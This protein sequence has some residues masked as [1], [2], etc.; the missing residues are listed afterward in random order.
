MSR[1]GYE[2]NDTICCNAIADVRIGQHHGLDLFPGLQARNDPPAIAWHLWPG[3]HELAGSELRCQ[4]GAMGSDILVKHLWRLLVF[5]QNEKHD[6][7]FLKSLFPLE[8][9]QS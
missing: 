5:K 1:T 2:L 9:N 6:I 7:V 8:H 3:H 4:M